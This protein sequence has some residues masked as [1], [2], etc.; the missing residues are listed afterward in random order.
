ML[1]LPLLEADGQISICRMRPIAKMVKLP[2]IVRRGR[3]LAR[4]RYSTEFEETDRL[5]LQF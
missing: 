3:R 5:D 2:T 4:P 1:F